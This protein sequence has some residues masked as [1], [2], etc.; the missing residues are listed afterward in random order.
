MR[1]VV[2]LKKTNSSCCKRA[3]F[4]ADKSLRISPL[5]LQ[6]NQCDLR[7]TRP[8]SLFSW[9]TCISPHSDI[10]I[11]YIKT[12]GLETWHGNIHVYVTY[13]NNGWSQAL[14]RSS[15]TACMR[16][17][18]ASLRTDERS[19]T[20]IGGDAATQKLL[21]N[22]TIWWSDS[23]HS[24]QGCCSACVFIAMTTWLVGI[25]KRE[26]ALICFI[27]AKT[28]PLNG[29]TAR[30]HTKVDVQQTPLSVITTICRRE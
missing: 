17:R 21:S 2:A 19:F 3:Y 20:N 7:G 14:W 24:R 29:R 12:I 1:D 8:Y 26:V 18:S 22:E 23:H 16:S 5:A 10:I 27:L 13:R 9:V 28:L 4:I 11:Q 15:S 6:T 25:W 30:L